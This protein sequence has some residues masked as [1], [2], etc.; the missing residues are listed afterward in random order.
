MF[1]INLTLK[2]N[3]T[4]RLLWMVNINTF[5]KN[6]FSYFFCKGYPTINKDLAHRSRQKN[7]EKDLAIVERL[8]KT[9]TRRNKKKKTLKNKLRR[10]SVGILD[11]SKKKRLTE[12]LCCY[13]AENVKVEIVQASGEADVYIAKNVSIN[14]YVMSIGKINFFFHDLESSN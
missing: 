2:K 14:D 13:F 12:G 8:L 9:R 1:W 4:S 11:F 6:S 3:Q 7:F 5:L 10:L